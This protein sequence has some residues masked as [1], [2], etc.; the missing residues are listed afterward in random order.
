MSEK[1]KMLNKIALLILVITIISVCAFISYD[2]S[3]SFSCESE[4]SIV[5]SINNEDVHSEGII[6]LE[7]TR[8]NIFISIDGLL[9]YND[10]KHIISRK[11]KA[12]YKRANT[13]LHWYKLSKI[14]QSRDDSDNINENI[15]NDL[16]FGTR[17]KDKIT[18]EKIVEDKIIYLNKLNN[19]LLLIGNHTFP[20]YG[21]KRQ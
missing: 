5:Q 15:A 1:R 16:L 10:N 9:T 17:S 20:Q 11:L 12:D 3:T 2:S 21:C 19:N 8:S 6:S 14:K 13:G 18:A 7:M 4:F